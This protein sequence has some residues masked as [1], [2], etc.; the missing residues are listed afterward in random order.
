MT[1]YTYDAVGRLIS[2]TH[3]DGSKVSY[4]YDVNGN[5]KRMED[6]QGIT[7]SIYD[8]LNPSR[9]HDVPVEQGIGFVYDAGSRRENVIYHP[10]Q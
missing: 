10:L 9:I 4:A 5:R 7:N 1:P 2:K 6:A 3:A 8:A